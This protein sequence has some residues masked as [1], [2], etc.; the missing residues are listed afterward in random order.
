MATVRPPCAGLLSQYAL[1][2]A[3]VGFGI[4]TLEPASSDKSIRAPHPNGVDTVPVSLRCA[5][6]SNG[7]LHTQNEPGKT[8]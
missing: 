7:L 2:M 6:I 4:D 8:T 5:Q 3:K 1:G